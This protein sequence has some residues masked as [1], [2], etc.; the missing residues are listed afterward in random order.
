MKDE[1]KQLKKLVGTIVYVPMIVNSVK[2][3]LLHGRPADEARRAKTELAEA[4]I[5]LLFDR[6]LR[7]LL[8]YHVFPVKESEFYKLQEMQREAVK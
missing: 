7:S 5:N 6:P 4:Y 2:I 1:V 8:D 3:E